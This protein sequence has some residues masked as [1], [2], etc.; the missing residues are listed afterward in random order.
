MQAVIYL[1]MILGVGGYSLARGFRLGMTGQLATLLG[2]AF[3][4]VGARILTPEFQVNFTWV[5]SFSPAP[6]FNVPAINLVC[7]VTIYFVIFSLFSILSGLLRGAMSVFEVGMFNR[8]LGSFFNCLKNLLWL[9]I[10]FNLLLCFSMGSGLLRF[11]RSG[12]GNLVSAVMALTPAI[13]GCYGAED[14][15]HIEQLKEAKKISCNFNGSG[16]VIKEVVEEET[17]KEKLG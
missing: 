6:E 2:F 11:E 1:L 13:L 7:G 9:S 10:L 14:I 5:S 16:S 12:D 17:G 4:A 15:S 8:L 3:G